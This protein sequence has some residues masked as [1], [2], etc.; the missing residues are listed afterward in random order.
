VLFLI[1]AVFAIIAIVIRT[2]YRKRQP[3]LR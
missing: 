2:Y 1:V 3:W